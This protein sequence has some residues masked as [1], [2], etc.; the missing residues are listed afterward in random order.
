VKSK[1]FENVNNGLFYGTIGALLA[2]FSKIP[3][4]I[5]GCPLTLWLFVAF[6]VLLRLKIYL[7]DYKYFST[8]DN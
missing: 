7:D 4:S 5:Q 3:S 1:L 2:G 8:N 6:F